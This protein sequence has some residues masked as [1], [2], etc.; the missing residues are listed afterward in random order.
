MRELKG[1]TFV[2]SVSDSMDLLKVG[3]TCT[4]VI[5]QSLSSV[6]LLYCVACVL[7]TCS[8]TCCGPEWRVHSWRW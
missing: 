8:I 3:L 2:F 5:V 6:Q 1:D 7:P 4:V